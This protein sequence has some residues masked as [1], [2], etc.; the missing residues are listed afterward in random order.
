MS[1][2]AALVVTNRPAFIPWWTHQIRKQTRQVDEV[3][4]VTNAPSFE[5]YANLA[6]LT[7]VE[8][9]LVYHQPPEPWV[10]LGWMRQK[11]LD[12]CSSDILLWMDD[13]D[14]Y[15]PRRTEFSCPPIESGRYDAA[16]FPLTH[17]YYLSNRTICH[18]QTD[19]VMHLP[20]VAWRRSSVLS[21]KFFHVRAVEDSHWIDRVARCRWARPLIP[22]DRI[23]WVTDYAYPHIGAMIV[24][25]GA[26]TWQDLERA[27]GEDDTR[28]PLY[29]FPP[30][31]VTKEEWLY[32]VDALDRMEVVPQGPRKKFKP[33]NDL[34]WAVAH[35]SSLSE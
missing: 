9:T 16:V 22:G 23:R 27:N 6:E 33:S 14:W 7:Q 29:R 17:H 5:P 25:H 11:A 20:A 1:T 35:R 3:V 31:G 28:S 13:D 8:N 4:V 26:N 10:S 2:V 19:M 34:Q 12:L 15:H 24:V 18:L 21:A 30:K 32:T